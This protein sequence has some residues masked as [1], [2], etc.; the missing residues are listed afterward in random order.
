MKLVTF[1]FGRLI[2]IFNETSLARRLFTFITAANRTSSLGREYYTLCHRLI[3][4]QTSIQ[5]TKHKLFDV[6][7]ELNQQRFN[8]SDLKEKPS[9]WVL[10]RFF[11]L[12]NTPTFYNNSPFCEYITEVIDEV[13]EDMQCNYYIDPN[14]AV[15]KL[16]LWV[17]NV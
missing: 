2:D 17:T 1:L 7:Y 3:V 13:F 5:E 4:T 12:S 9:K 14:K 8:S 15:E 6:I 16:L 10:R 11:I